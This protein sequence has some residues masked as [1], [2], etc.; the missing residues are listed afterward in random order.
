MKISLQIQG[1]ESVQQTLRKL[2][3][4]AI[5][6]A[7]V[8]AIN[9]TAFLARREVQREMGQV[10]DRPTPYIMRSVQVQQATP[11]RPM[12]I[13]EPTY[14]GG[15]GVDPANVLAAQVAGGP[16]K[17]KRS[18]RA[19]QLAGILPS[20]YFTAIPKVPFPG[21]DDGRGNL[22]GP[23]MVQLLSYFRA[24]SEQGYSANMT[25][26]RRKKL[27]NIG[28][29]ASGAKSINGVVYFV[30]YG[31]LRSGPGQHLKAGIWAKTGTHGVNVRP[32]LMFVRAPTYKAAISAA[33]IVQ[34]AGIQAYFEKRLR[35]RIRVAAGV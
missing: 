35:Y 28:T 34:R 20:G 4:P 24:F 16:R 17:L 6:E 18:E 2:S 27:H 1:L 11:D 7:T 3:G 32:V 13:V 19:L 29:N 33:P 31:G 9:D 8:K 25:D 5:Y 12:A 22:R 14:M 30:T 21:S 10:F 15:K 26:R 23:F